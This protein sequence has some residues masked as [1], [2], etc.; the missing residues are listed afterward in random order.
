MEALSPPNFCQ[1]FLAPL[2]LMSFVDVRLGRLSENY[3]DGIPL[4]LACT[5]SSKHTGFNP[6]LSLHLH[7]PRENAG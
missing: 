7:L 3:I 6:Q 2:V 1:H 5:I 4:D